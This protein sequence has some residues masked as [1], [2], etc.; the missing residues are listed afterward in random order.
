[1]GKAA[2]DDLRTILAYAAPTSAHGRLAIDP[3]LA[4]GLSYYTGAIVEVAVSD[5][6]GSLGGGG[7]YD[8]LVGMFSNQSVPA[9]GFS[10]GLE[11]II[12]VMTERGMFP[13]E[14]DNDAAPADVM[15]TVWNAE[16]IG[17]ALALARDLR[18]ADLPGGRRLR[19]DVYPE[20]DKIGKQF[21]YAGDRKIPHVVVAGD[22]ELAQGTV[23][24]KNMR[25]GEQKTVRREAAA[26]A[27]LES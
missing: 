27:L 3:S 14:L 4:R 26:T 1:V 5:L 8:N 13:A 17:D 18:A 25:T 12:V 6:A 11:R 23:T 15:V 9:A 20:A 24:I 2:L 22:D 21:K 7:R 19:V 16:K 10:L